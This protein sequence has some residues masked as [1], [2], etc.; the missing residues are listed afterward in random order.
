MGASESDS[1][2]A[3]PWKSEHFRTIVEQNAD[4]ILI[5]DRDGTI[6]YANQAAQRILHRSHDEIVGAKWGIA[7]DPE[8][9]SELDI[10]RRDGTRAVVEMRAV[11]LQEDG[12]SY[13]ASL[14][15][16]SEHKRLVRELNETARKLQN[17]VEHLRI[18]TY[19]AGHDLREPLR[20]IRVYLD[21]LAE[22]HHDALDDEAREFIGRAADGATRLRHLIDDLSLY[23]RVETETLELHETDCVELIDDVL[24]D[25]KDAVLDSGAV[26]TVDIL[27]K[28]KADRRQ[29]KHVFL[30]LLENAVK[31]RS[32]RPLL[33][34]VSGEEVDGSVVFSVSDNGIGI[35]P[36]FQRNVFQAFERLHGRADYPGTGIGLALCEKI[37]SRH[38]G[39]IWVESQPGR[40]STF[41]FSLPS[42]PTVVW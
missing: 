31:F 11:A 3:D 18:V 26:V 39:R 29:L 17:T 16:V 27:P 19:I 15:D 20:S 12:L 14:R 2:Y 21:L 36:E 38:G 10:L 5:V 4:G 8:S 1:G 33:I 22:R 7:A 9:T 23:T 37:V 24:D 25:L 6:A 41:F 30:N 28:V 13:L 42:D 35:E 40:G 34:V 32:E